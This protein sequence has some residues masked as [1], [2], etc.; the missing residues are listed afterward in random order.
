[1]GYEWLGQI[2]ALTKIAFLPELPR[3]LSRNRRGHVDLA[4][5]GE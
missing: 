1:M 2:V 3:Q 5:D 4:Q